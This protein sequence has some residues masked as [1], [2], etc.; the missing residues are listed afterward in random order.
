MGV[1]IKHP[2]LLS[3]IPSHSCH[4]ISGALEIN[5]TTLNRGT[6]RNG[7][8]P[9]ITEKSQFEKEQYL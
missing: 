9:F 6:S 3:I 4:L 1:R 5:Q 8:L 7:N 2:C